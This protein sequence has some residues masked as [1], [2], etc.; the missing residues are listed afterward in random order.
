MAGDVRMALDI[1]R[2]AVETVEA[3]VRHQRI[4]APQGKLQDFY[5]HGDLLYPNFIKET[6]LVYI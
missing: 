1:C 3:E 4:A 5:S 2:R 6:I